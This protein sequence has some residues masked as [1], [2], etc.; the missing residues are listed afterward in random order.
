MVTGAG[1]IRKPHAS[2]SHGESVADDRGQWGQALVRSLPV[3]SR[4]AV[5]TDTHGGEPHIAPGDA[6]TTAS[7]NAS[8]LLGCKSLL[9]PTHP[10]QPFTPLPR[11]QPLLPLALLAITDEAS[12]LALRS[13]RNRPRTAVH[14]RCQLLAEGE[15]ERCHRGVVACHRTGPCQKFARNYATRNLVPPHSATLGSAFH[16][17]G[18]VG[19]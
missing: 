10:S 12:P 5:I 4:S 16:L 2:Y 9:K 18:C 13:T 7:S 3:R 11:N 8:H 15:S 6:G 14:Q 17:R 19:R 1:C